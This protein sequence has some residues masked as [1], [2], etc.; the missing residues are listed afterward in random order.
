MRPIEVV[1][2]LNID[3]VSTTARVPGPG[4]TLQASSFSTGF[5]GKGANQAVAAARL[6]DEHA[7]SSGKAVRIVGAVGRDQFGEDF[8]KQLKTEGIDSSDVRVVDTAKTGSTIIVVEESTGEN[9]ILFTPAANFDFEPSHVQLLP[10]PSLVVLQLEIP[11]QTVRTQAPM[12]TT[13]TG[14]QLML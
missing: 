7:R 1:G 5:G 3:L 12:P 13:S 4:E 8:L 14:S 2:S 10:D 6:L 9:R 11:F